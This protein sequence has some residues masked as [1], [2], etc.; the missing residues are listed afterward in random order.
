MV[1]GLLG[2]GILAGGKGRR[3]GMDKAMV[4]LMGRSLL[5]WAVEKASLLGIPV[6][7]LSGRRTIEGVECLMDKK[8]E[9]PMA[10]LLVALE[11]FE[12]VL[13]F[14]VDMPFLHPG[15]LA[16]LLREGEGRDLLVCRVGGEIQPQ[17]G[18]YSR[19]CLPFVEE[20]LERGAWSLKGLLEEPLDGRVLEE[21]EVALWGNPARLFFNINTPEDLERA[22]EMEGG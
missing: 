14:P 2:V 8:G 22:R 7:V 5:S 17:V 6:V 20:R 4:P 16:F 11:V 15:F 10:G 19:R 3:L 1:K 18:V 9:G 12:R 13:L 21:D